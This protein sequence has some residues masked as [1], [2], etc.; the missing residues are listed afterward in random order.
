ME[1]RIFKINLDLISGMMT[2]SPPSATKVGQTRPR[3]RRHRSIVVLYFRPPVRT[4]RKVSVRDLYVMDS[5]QNITEDEAELYDRQI[6]LWG[7]D[8]Q[9][10]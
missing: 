6:R 8:A 3:Y 2:P 1:E 9:K 10:R 5:L 7:L 4:E